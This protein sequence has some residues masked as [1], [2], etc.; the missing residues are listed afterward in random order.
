[1]DSYI[2]LA[3]NTTTGRTRTIRVRHPKTGATA[4][5][6]KNAME[7]MVASDALRSK[8]GWAA[9]PRRAQLVEKTAKQYF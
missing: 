4:A 7:A 9:S 8:S 5:E 2:E 6:V 3:F 1:M